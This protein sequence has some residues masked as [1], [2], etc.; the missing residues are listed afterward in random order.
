MNRV[1]FMH[2]TTSVEILASNNRLLAPNP[3]M[4]YKIFRRSKP[5]VAL[6]TTVAKKNIYKVRREGDELGG[7]RNAKRS[8][9]ISM[10]YPL[11]VLRRLFEASFAGGLHRLP[12]VAL[13]PLV[14]GVSSRRSLT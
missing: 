10:M 11:S 14:Q 7:I 8:I 13:S 1:Y 6:D 9:K 12:R 3:Y 5:K 4:I 2:D